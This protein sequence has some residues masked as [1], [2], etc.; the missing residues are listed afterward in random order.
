M[1]LMSFAVCESMLDYAGCQAKT[2]AT[3][4]ALLLFA[5]AEPGKPRLFGLAV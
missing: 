3:A 5:A 1:V 2:A 4:T